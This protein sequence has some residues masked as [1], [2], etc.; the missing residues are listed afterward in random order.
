[1]NLLC[2]DVMEDKL[3]GLMMDLQHSS[4]FLRTPKMSSGKDYKSFKALAREWSPESPIQIL[5]L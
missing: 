3:K 2:I 1:M 4:L 5:L